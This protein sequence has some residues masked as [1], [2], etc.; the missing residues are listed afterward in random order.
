MRI[1]GKFYYELYQF[2]FDG[3]YYQF[4]STLIGIHCGDWKSCFEMSKK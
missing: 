3:L 1:T 2:Y 4:F